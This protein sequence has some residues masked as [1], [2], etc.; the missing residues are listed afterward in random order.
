MH[1]IEDLP[2]KVAEAI[3]GAKMNT[4]HDRLNELLGIAEGEPK[5]AG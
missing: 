2:A 3:Q 5:Q 1:R 4:A